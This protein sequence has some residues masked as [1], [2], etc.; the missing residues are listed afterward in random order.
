LVF[1]AK[2]ET[3]N[4]WPLLASPLRLKGTPP[5]TRELMR[6]LG[7]D[8]DAILAELEVNEPTTKTARQEA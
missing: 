7:S 5:I 3:G 1:Y 8:G 2:D 6:P 4:E